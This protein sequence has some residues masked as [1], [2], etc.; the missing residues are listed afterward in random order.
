MLISSVQQNES[1]MHK[2]S[3][4]YSCCVAC[5][6]SLSF[7]FTVS[8]LSLI[9][10]GL[11]MPCSYLIHCHPLL[12]LPLIFPS[13]R[14]LSNESAFCIKWPN[15]WSFNFNISP[16]NEYLGLIFFRIDWFD[17][18]AVQGALKSLVQNHNS[19]ASVP[20]CLAFFMVQL[21]HPYMITGKNHS[22]DYMVLCTQSNVSAF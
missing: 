4:I 21:S 18:L 13:I 3:H 11:V 9:S 5:Q 22:F 7:I 17:L 1:V 19:K 10:I 20:Q 16:S 14:G 12:H 2:H 6:A 15:Y 8:L